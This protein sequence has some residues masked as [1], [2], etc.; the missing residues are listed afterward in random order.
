MAYQPTPT[1]LAYWDRFPLLMHLSKVK[2][3]VHRQWLFMDEITEEADCPRC[4]HVWTTVDLVAWR[5]AHPPRPAS[6]LPED[7]RRYYPRQVTCPQCRDRL[8]LN[9]HDAT[10]ACRRC[11]ATWTFAALVDIAAQ[12]LMEEEPHGATIYRKPRH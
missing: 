4:G 7:L 5:D 9:L 6:A 1:L 8:R 11:D 3:P 12:Q 2:C 10:G